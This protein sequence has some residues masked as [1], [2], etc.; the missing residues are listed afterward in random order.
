MKRKI[1]FIL[2]ILSILGSL[3]V[4]YGGTGLPG[5]GFLALPMSSRAISMGNA[6]TGVSD[7]VNCQFINPA[8]MAGLNHHEISVHNTF[9]M[10]DMNYNNLAFAYILP[11]GV[12]G[13]SLVL[14]YPGK[15]S[16]YDGWGF[17]KSKLTMYDMAANVNYGV[18]IVDSIYSGIGIKYIYRRISE[19]SDRTVDFDAGILFKISFLKIKS[20]AANKELNDNV[21]IGLSFQNIMGKIGKDKLP[22]QIR[23]GIRYSIMPALACSVDHVLKLYDNNEF[24]T[25]IEYIYMRQFSIRAGYIVGDNSYLFTSG[26]GANFKIGYSLYKVDY[27]YSPLAF[28]YSVHSLNFSIRFQ[29]S[30]KIAKI[31]ESGDNTRVKNGKDSRISALFN[32]SMDYYFEGNYDKAIIKLKKIIDIDPHYPR[33]NEKIREIEQLKKVKAQ[34]IE[35]L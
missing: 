24:N 23:S 19:Y 14:F 34:A 9:W 2:F 6:F 26:M 3:H 16:A 33:V 29:T 31:K 4:A 5:A 27:S 1:L 21:A 11:K 22:S 17:E 35:N 10:Y 15:V 30:E 28:D 20:I 13:S 18:K 8:G 32:E 7:D 12:V 25:G